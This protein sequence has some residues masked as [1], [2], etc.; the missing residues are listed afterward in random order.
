MP[1]ASGRGCSRGIKRRASVALISDAGTP[2]VSDP[3]YKLVR[4]ALG[5]RPAGDQHPGPLG[6]TRRA[7]QRRPADRHLSLCRLPAAEIGRAPD[8]A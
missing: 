1:S 7:D 3:G 6:S 2:L 5:R 8:A 4:E